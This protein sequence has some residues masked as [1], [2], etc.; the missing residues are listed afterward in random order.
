MLQVDKLQFDYDSRPILRTV[1]F[2]LHPGQLIHIRGANGVGKTSLLKLLAGLMRPKSGEIRYHAS[3]VYDDLASYQKDLAFVGH[4]AGHSVLLTV[5][6]NL[7]SIASAA[8]FSL[9]DRYI[10][11]FG[12]AHV[13]DERCGLLSA[14]ERRRVSLLRLLLTDKALWLLDEPLTSLDHS[15]IELISRHL[16]RHL[17]K[18]GLIVLS[19]HQPISIKDAAYQELILS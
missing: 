7:A 14:G 11:E 9:I 13:R 2:T 1:S 8:K 10:N 15:A 18:G 4:K 6:E 17:K 5:Y 12:L 16:L 19:S 3:N